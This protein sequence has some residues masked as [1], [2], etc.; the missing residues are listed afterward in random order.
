MFLHNPHQTGDFLGQP[1]QYPAIFS[2]KATLVTV[3]STDFVQII[4][5]NPERGKLLIWNKGENDVLISHYDYAAT[6]PTANEAGSL[7][8]KAGGFF[9]D[10]YPAFTGFYYAKAISGTSTLS[11]RDFLL[12]LYSPAM[13]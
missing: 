13:N 5:V 12:T 8:L 10:N 4:D 9:S 2:T 1:E 6:E 7:I 11:I 3:N